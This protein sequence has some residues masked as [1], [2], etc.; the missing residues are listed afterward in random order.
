PSPSGHI[1]RYA[2][3]DDYHGRLKTLLLELADACARKVQRPVLARACVDTAPLL[4]REA[5]RRAGRSFFG[6]NTLAIVPGVGS[7]VLLGELLLDVEL[8][9]GWRMAR[10]R[11]HTV[12]RTGCGSCTRCL[13][14]CP[15][16]AFVGPYQLDARR[17]ISYLTIEYDG[18]I[19]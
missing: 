14:A 6:K 16:G 18:V 2:R 13:D 8:A 5:A 15:T 11:R 10:A 12:P 17:C 9:P 4:E 19:P 7:Y 3:G 1:A